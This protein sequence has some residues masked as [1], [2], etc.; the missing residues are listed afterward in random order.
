MPNDPMADPGVSTD[1]EIEQELEIVRK[2]AL[3][4]SRFRE[5]KDLE[6]LVQQKNSKIIS[7]EAENVRLKMSR[8][9]KELATDVEGLRKEVGAKDR[10]LVEL[11]RTIASMKESEKITLHRAS[12]LDQKVLTLQNTLGQMQRA[13]D[14]AN[15]SANAAESER[16]D[17]VRNF[18]NVNDRVKTLEAR[19]K[20]LEPLADAVAK[21]PPGFVKNYPQLQALQAMLRQPEPKKAKQGK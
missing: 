13:R 3:I 11:D 10:R 2:N 4:E 9:D 7:L 20:V 1:K 17:A 14:L 18:V 6:K 19:L 15:A 21:L 8:T 16:L 5:I 12:E